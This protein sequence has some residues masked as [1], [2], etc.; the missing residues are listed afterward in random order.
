MDG[1]RYICPDHQRACAECAEG[2]RKWS[3]IFGG[4]ARRAVKLEIEH[5]YSI[6][7]CMGDGCDMQCIREQV[8][9]LCM[10][11]TLRVSFAHEVGWPWIVTLSRTQR[12]STLVVLAVEFQHA[13]R[14][15]QKA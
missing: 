4:V 8:F 7:R 12:L 10:L 5:M 14:V 6:E 1:V 15:F 2:Y 11:Y 3:S 13:T 9:L